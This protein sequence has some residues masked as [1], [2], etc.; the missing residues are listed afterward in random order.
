MYIEGLKLLNF[1][2]YYSQNLEF[3]KGINIIYGLNGT[4]KTNIV[5]AIYALSLT[6]SFRTTNDSLMISIDKNLAKIEGNININ[7]QKNNYQLIFQNKEKKVKINGNK[8]T[9]LSDYV[10]NMYVILFNP[11]DLKIIK[12]SPA[13]RRRFIDI[14]LSQ[15]DKNYIVYL[16]YYNKLIKQRNIYLREMYINGTL[17]KD[18]LNIITEK[19]IDY[20]IKIYETRKKYINEISKY[21]SNIYLKIFENGK[22]KVNYNSD[23]SVNKKELL[24]KY[25]SNLKK[26]LFLG[27]TTIGIHR[28]EFEF[29][30][31]NYLLKEYG[32]E[33]QQKNALIA[34]KLAEIEVVK[35]IKK[36]NPIIVF[37]DLSSVLDTKK[38]DNI[39]SIINDD[40]QTFITT[41]NINLINS[42]I[43]KKS[44]IFKIENNNVEVENYEWR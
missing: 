40:I 34:F 14:Q 20:G 7:N 28:D 12:D 29:L 38:I 25:N 32:S 36:I 21:I 35:N 8:I 26:D 27:K 43:L 5:E 17:S 24:K 37:D 4:G 22:L 2:S 18:Y 6:K 19:I 16:N 42:E 39:L 33:G 13:V 15:L 10:S 41:S 11:D 1:R 23:F 9:R 30:L 31:D 44:K 3:S